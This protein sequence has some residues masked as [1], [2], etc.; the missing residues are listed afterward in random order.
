MIGSECGGCIQNM[1]F[2]KPLLLEFFF[3]FFF[4][5][6]AEH[7][8]VVCSLSVFQQVQKLSLQMLAHPHLPFGVTPAC[9]SNSLPS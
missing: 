9:K 5:P 8:W 6:T 7:P 3:S 2:G 1:L 4:T